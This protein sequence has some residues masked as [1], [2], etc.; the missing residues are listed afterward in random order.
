MERRI[1]KRDEIAGF[2]LMNDGS[3][4]ILLQGNEGDS[5]GQSA[6][7]MNALLELDSQK[8]GTTA[9]LLDFGL[10]VP[11]RKTKLVN[12]LILLTVMLAG[13]LISLGIV[14]EKQDNTVNAINVTPVSQNIF[15]MGKS[16]IGGIVAL[17]GIAALFITGYYDINWLL[18]ILVGLSSTIL[19]MVIGFV[20]G[21]GS[22]DIIEA[23]TGMEI[24]DVVYGRFH[25]C[26]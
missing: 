25:R 1:L 2:L 20:Q 24:D 6:A 12:M 14:E 18:I 23:A 16:L 13:M 9:K 17:T 15:I 5:I 4:E 7:T 10:T 22:D 19:T 21:I 8:E 26:V 11:P 3:Y